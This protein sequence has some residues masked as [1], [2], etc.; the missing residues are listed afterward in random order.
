MKIK[1]VVN[2]KALIKTKNTR[3]EGIELLRILIMFM[4]LLLHFNLKGGILFNNSLANTLNYKLVW[5]VE[6]FSI[7]AVNCFVLI[8]GYFLVDSEF[9]KT[10]IY[11]LVLQVISYSLVITILY[12]VIT[13]DVLSI[14]QYLKCIFPVSF[15]TY[16]FITCYIILYLLVPYLN[17]IFKYTDKRKMQFL[18]GILCTISFI[19]WILNRFGFDVIDNTKGYGIIWFINLYFIGGY[20]R[21]YYKNE[22]NKFYYLIIYIV[23]SLL[24]FVLKITLP[25]VNSNAIW[26][27]DIFYEYNSIT[28]TLQSI[29]LFMFFKDL[30]IKNENVR[31]TIL[32]VAPLTLAVY[33]V[34]EHPLVSRFLYQNWLHLNAFWNSKYYIIIT[35]FMSLAIYAVCC[36][37]EYLRSEIVK[38]LERL[39]AVHTHT[40]TVYFNE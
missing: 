38:M 35:F 40:H 32:G 2:E 25:K 34:H 4:V 37:I 18:I 22:C 28:V 7:V 33:I 20:I 26:I 23:C 6:A 12:T 16:W 39:D 13:K 14:R 1:E 10:K 21:R 24:I 8:S 30:K 15:K 5:L 36:I 31:K 9:K 27:S 19:S 17:L 29:C 11:S 3:S